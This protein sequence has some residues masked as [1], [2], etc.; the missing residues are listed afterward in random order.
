MFITLK[1]FWEWLIKVIVEII[2]MVF[3]TNWTCRLRHGRKEGPCVYCRSQTF[4][5]ILFCTKI[6]L[7]ARSFWVVFQSMAVMI[8]IHGYC[9]HHSKLPDAHKVLCSRGDVPECRSL[10]RSNYESGAGRRRIIEVSRSPASET[11]NPTQLCD[12]WYLAD[13]PGCLKPAAQLQIKQLGY[14]TRPA[15][16]DDR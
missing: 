14:L 2:S 5:W 1:F 9:Q 11:T 10:V 13:R 3:R 4:A 6:T 16:V 15:T 12:G 8:T 7:A